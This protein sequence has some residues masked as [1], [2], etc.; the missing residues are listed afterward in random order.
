MEFQKE[1]TALQN[2]MHSFLKKIISQTLV[3]IQNVV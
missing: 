1:L 2:Q 3:Q